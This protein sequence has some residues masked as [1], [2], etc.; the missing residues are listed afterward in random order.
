[1]KSRSL[2]RPLES[3]DNE[4]LPRGQYGTWFA[5][6]PISVAEAYDLQAV[7]ELAF[8]RKGK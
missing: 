6:S 7:G 3:P 1:V 4:T 8:S 5:A 2:Y